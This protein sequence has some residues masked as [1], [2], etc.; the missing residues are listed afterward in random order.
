[1]KALKYALTYITISTT[2]SACGQSQMAQVYNK[3]SQFFGHTAMQSDLA[4]RM[5]QDPAIA[6][7][8]HS[9]AQ[10]ATPASLDSVSSS[11]LPPPAASPASAK[12]EPMMKFAFKQSANAPSASAP[13]TP[14][15]TVQQSPVVSSLQ[16][17][18]PVTQLVSADVSAPAFIWPADGRV[19]SSFG[20]KSNGLV[21]DGINIEA[22]EGKPIWAAASGEVV[23]AGNGLKDYGNLMIVRHEGGWMT[24]Y[25]HASDMLVRKGMKV[26]QGDL[27]GYVG[28]TGDVQTAQ[29]HFGIRNGKSPVNPETLLPQ[30][31]ATR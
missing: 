3:G 19:I 16:P 13:V 26:S 29:L 28:K 1:M 9:D 14:A 25:G 21:N 22:A 7:K 27:L 6:E 17:V 30:R 31:V 2:L 15:P 12:T 23:Y 20:P 8:Y 18:R 5:P 11:D 4:L 24:A 10:Y